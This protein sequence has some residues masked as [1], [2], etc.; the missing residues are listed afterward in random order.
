MTND[1]IYDAIL[2]VIAFII[3]GA[4]GLW[5]GGHFDQKPENKN[6]KKK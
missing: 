1:P 5:L 3:G 6:G 4:I 2:C